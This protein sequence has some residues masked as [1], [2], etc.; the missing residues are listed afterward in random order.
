MTKAATVQARVETKLKKQADS[1]LKKIGI[2]A[3]QVINALYAQIVMRKGIPFELR[4]PNEET[5]N[6]I[7]ELESGKGKKFA[8]FKEMLED[9][10]EDD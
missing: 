7:N 9:E 2:S 8:T 3:S 5:R 1:I 6:A 4:I 10:L